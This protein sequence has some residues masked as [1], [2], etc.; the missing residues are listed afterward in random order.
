VLN[1]VPWDAVRIAKATVRSLEA[2]PNGAELILF[3]APRTEAG[4][5]EMH[6]GWW[7]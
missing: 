1:L 2:D 4:D 5:A 6:Q 3:G 7:H